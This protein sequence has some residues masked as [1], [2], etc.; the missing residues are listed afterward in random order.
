MFYKIAGVKL[1]AEA[2]EKGIVLTPVE[3]TVQIGMQ[4]SDA[5]ET[6][7]IQLSKGEW[8]QFTNLLRHRVDKVLN[9]RR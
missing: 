4:D 8:R 3:V 6:H 5:V 7:V 9:E 1:Q 2:N